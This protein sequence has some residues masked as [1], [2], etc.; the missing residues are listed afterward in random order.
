ML[1]NRVS[2]KKEQKSV[3]DKLSSEDRP[4]HQTTTGQYQE[5]ETL[6][7]TMIE[8]VNKRKNN[9]QQISSLMQ[10]FDGEVESANNI[11]E[12]ISSEVSAISNTFPV[13][14]TVIQEEIDQVSH[15][16]LINVCKVFT[17]CTLM[18]P[19]LYLYLSIDRSSLE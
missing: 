13:E 15:V 3:S 12:E 4:S 19:L 7:G 9:L 5:L 14:I 10:K 6:W 18:L 11:L 8:K 17:I 16:I 1:Q 2:E